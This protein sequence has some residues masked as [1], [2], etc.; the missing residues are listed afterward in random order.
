MWER[1]EVDILRQRVVFDFE[2][3]AK[4]E[5][6]CWNLRPVVGGAKSFEVWWRQ[7]H[8]LPMTRGDWFELPSTVSQND[9]VAI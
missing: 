5:L 6:G 7:D 9:H 8:D 3:V 4:F 1:K 2:E